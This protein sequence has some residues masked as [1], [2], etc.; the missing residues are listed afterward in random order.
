LEKKKTTGIWGFRHDKK[1]KSR[2]IN[3][4]IDFKIRSNA[5]GFGSRYFGFG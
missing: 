4:Q 2:P 5:I 3:V 1:I